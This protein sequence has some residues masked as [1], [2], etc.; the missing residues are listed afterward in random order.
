MARPERDLPSAA[1]LLDIVPLLTEQIHTIITE[2]AS[3][4]ITPKRK[5]PFPDGTP[6][7]LEPNGGPT[8]LSSSPSNTAS[9][10]SKKLHQ[11]QRIILSI[12]GKLTEL[13]SEPS[14]RIIEAAC[15]Y[16]ESR[17]LAIAAE[18]R[19]PDLLD[20]AQGKTMD[21][22]EIAEKTGIEE[23]KLGEASVLFRAFLIVLAL[24]EAN[25]WG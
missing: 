17:A 14:E 21:V 22:N 12:C 10:A 18:R 13:V 20:N 23:G 8:T 5:D 24:P 15:Q 3:E 25:E 6:D 16:W 1:A 7:G 19:I 9:L 4:S 2:W 11:A